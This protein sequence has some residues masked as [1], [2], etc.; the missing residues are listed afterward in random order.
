MDDQKITI[1]SESIAKMIKFPENLNDRLI[2]HHK[3][4]G[5][6]PPLED[7]EEPYINI[8][9]NL[10][11]TQFKTKASVNSRP[12]VSKDAIGFNLTCQ[13]GK[14][15]RLVGQRRDLK[16]DSA[17]TLTIAPSKQSKAVNCPCPRNLISSFHVIS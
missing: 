12:T 14:N 1:P 8:I 5:N 10:M 3:P 6:E 7:N 2:F 13:H 9:S 4:R 11:T 16:Q 15:F 17:W